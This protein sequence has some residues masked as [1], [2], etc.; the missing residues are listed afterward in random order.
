MN[1]L[2]A[3]YGAIGKRHLG[4]LLKIDAIE[5][6]FIY[7]SLKQL[8]E[9]LSIAAQRKIE[10]IDTLAPFYGISYPNLNGDSL[11]INFAIIANETY[12]H[13]DTAI[14]LA[15]RGI[16][17][18]IEKPISHSLEKIDIFKTVIKKNKIKV[19][20]GYNLRFLG[21]IKYIKEQL[22]NGIIGDIYFAKI[23]VGQYLPTWRSNIDY[24]KSYSAF[25]ERGGGVTLDLSHEIDYMRYLFGEPFCWKVITAKVSKLEI[26]SD[27]IFE[28]LYRYNTNFICNVHMDYLQK[29]RK[30]EIRIEG[31]EGAIKCD[32]VKKNIKIIKNNVETII[33][34]DTK[35]DISKT[36]IDE[37]NH[38]VKVIKENKETDITLE[39]GI[40]ALILL[41]DGNV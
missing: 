27:D 25:S 19:F 35:F 6:I 7:T 10:F 33:D 17:L 18:F 11:E 5:K 31:S 13:L 36:Y 37:I 32:F 2:V 30:R 14:Y 39:D 22:S 9:D 40:K 8:P 41:T 4:N 26:S 16:N 21:A 15:E 28:G 12:K 34:D 24:R 38:F 29:N 3:G 1:V 20:V 23:E